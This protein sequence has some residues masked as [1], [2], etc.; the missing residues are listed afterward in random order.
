M[1]PELIGAENPSLIPWAELWMGIHPSAP[2]V[3]IDEENKRKIVL[4]DLIKENPEF[5]LGDETLKAFASLPFLFKVLA[6]DKPLSIQVHPNLEQAKAGWEKEN[7]AGI[8]IKAPN[9]NYK[10]PNHKPE[11]ICAL[12]PFTALCGFRTIEEI[13]SLL[14]L[15]HCRA[16][17][18]PLAALKD[19]SLKGEGGLK[20]FLAALF[21]MNAENRKMLTETILEN[22]KNFAVKHEEYKTEF[23]LCVQF[24]HMY[25]EDPSLI[26]PLYL[27]VI[28][29]KPGEAMFLSAGVLHSYVHGLGMELMANSDNVLRGGL[30]SKYI[31]ADELENILLF[32][33]FMPEILKPSTLKKSAFT[34]VFTYSTQCKDFALKHLQKEHDDVLYVDP[35]P[36]IIFVTGGSLT[37]KDMVDGRELVLKKGESAFLPPAGISGRIMLSGNFEIYSAS[38]GLHQ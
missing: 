18:V 4:V 22:G 36:S 28:Q 3:C 30:T 16:L 24:A 20:G 8:D 9:R 17:D 26:A 35:G 14:A 38:T 31:D 1:I 10:D 23:D 12:S 2:S 21:S 32:K 25:P 34:D 27:N 7:K 6:A 15:V 33:P 11:I 5:Y 19:T 37:I 29:L 13:E